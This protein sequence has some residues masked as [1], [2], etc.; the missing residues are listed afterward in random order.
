MKE[1]EYDIRLVIRYYYYYTEVRVFNIYLLLKT[2]KVTLNK[3]NISKNKR[4][5][6]LCLI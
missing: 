2:K 5:L 3:K 1:V 6:R 4:A